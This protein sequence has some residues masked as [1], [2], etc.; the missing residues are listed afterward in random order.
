MSKF[1]RKSPNLYDEKYIGQDL[2]IIDPLRGIKLGGS[3]RLNIDN[4]PDYEI[5]FN[6]YDGDKI[7]GAQKNINLRYINFPE[8]PQNDSFIYDGSSLFLDR[9]YNTLIGGSR[10][11]WFR[12]LD[13]LFED[14]GF[15]GTILFWVY[16]NNP[17]KFSNV[18]NTP[19]PFFSIAQISGVNDSITEG[20]KFYFGMY[21]Y[22]TSHAVY[23][24]RAFD[25]TNY[26]EFLGNGLAPV[27]DGI[28]MLSVNTLTGEFCVNGDLIYSS[29]PF[30][31]EYKARLQVLSDTENRT[32]GGLGMY[33][34]SFYNFKS[35]TKKELKQIYLAG[36]QTSNER[37]IL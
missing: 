36:V 6:M 14:P 7:V 8:I 25:D 33:S 20:E 27:D 31:I 30:L 21:A 16:I 17:V 32:G 37:L 15:V 24:G 19:K 10:Y 11:T 23:L 18:I 3:K 35:F 29:N 34:V 26:G 12:N 9:G 2:P 22:L 5:L 13:N 1:I 28:Y 4:D